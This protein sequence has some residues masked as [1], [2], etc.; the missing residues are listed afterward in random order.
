MGRL[1]KGSPPTYRKYKRTGQAVVTIDGKDYYL[2][3]YDTPESKAEYLRL[4]AEHTVSGTVNACAEAPEPTLVLEV[5]AKFW[6]HAKTWYVKNGEPTKEIDAYKK[7][8]ADLKSLYGHT[9]AADFGP[10]AFKAVRQKW[11]ER[12]QARP[13]INKNA[14]R[15]KRVFKW[16]VAEELVPASVYQSISTVEGLRRGR[17][18]S[19]EPAPILP[20]SIST[21]EKTLP[22]LPPVTQDMIRFQLLT[23]ARPGEVCSMRPVDIDQS[24]DVWEYHVGGHKTEHHG[25]SRTVYIGPEAQLVLSKYLDR[26][27]LLVCFSMAESLEQRRAA[28]SARRVT[29]KSCGNRRGYRSNSDRKGRKRR[30]NI[31]FQVAF[32]SDSYRRAIHYACD[33]AFPAGSPLGCREGETNSKRLARLTDGQKKELKIWQDSKRWSPNQLRHTRGTEIRK[34]FGLEAAQVILGHAVADVTQI[35]AERDADKAREVVR[36]IG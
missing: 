17:C 4:L 9:P 32:N 26:D 21:V 6:K 28:I 33:L 36:K 2:G 10:L 16:A 1:K 22:F 31:Q 5:I 25:R 20:V 15:L 7:I 13:T 19:R 8:F 11:I 29:P 30:R 27:E 24:R 23:G 12:G 18:T 34:Q 14:G 35:Y 3:P